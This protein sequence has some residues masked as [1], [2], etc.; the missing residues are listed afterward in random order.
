[1]SS[2]INY[3]LIKEIDINWL[4]IFKSFF[5]SPNSALKYNS[6]AKIS[7]QK[8][9]LKFIIAFSIFSGAL[10]F[11]EILSSTLKFNSFLK[12]WI[13]LIKSLTIPSWI[14]LSLRFVKIPTTISASQTE[15]KFLTDFS[16]IKKSSLVNSKLLFESDT[17]IYPYLSILFSYSA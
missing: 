10:I 12:F 16:L 14:R 2:N 15:E 7:L 1:M 8:Y 3:F 6:L 4:F 9:S 17:F 5:L 11:T 13:F